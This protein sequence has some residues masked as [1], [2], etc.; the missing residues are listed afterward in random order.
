M[1][2]SMLVCAV[3]LVSASAFADPVDHVKSP[4]ESDDGPRDNTFT[5]QVGVL[6]GLTLFGFDYT[7]VVSPHFDLS[8]SL[9][10]GSAF[11]DDT[12][13]AAVI[14]HLRATAGAWTFEAGVGPSVA[15]HTDDAMNTTTYP[16]LVGELLINY[17]TES[18]WIVQARGGAYGFCDG[19]HGGTDCS[20]L[21]GGPFGG[22]GLG[23]AF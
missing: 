13:Q 5:G 22:L 21:D 19:D 2:T 14:P 20:K 6:P 23:R 1:T 12:L 16:Q 10:F 17:R 8:G 3:T 4:T 9:S 11:G 7:R 15:R 18:N